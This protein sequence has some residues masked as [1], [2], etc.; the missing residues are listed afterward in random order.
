[1]V[2]TGTLILKCRDRI[3]VKLYIE[4]RVRSVDH[5]GVCQPKWVL[6]R[7]SEQRT[8]VGAGRLSVASVEQLVN[9]HK[10]DVLN[11]HFWVNTSP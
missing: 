9:W 2:A 6:L 4:F 1:M 11:I 10:K 3:E 7:L 5:C 8:E